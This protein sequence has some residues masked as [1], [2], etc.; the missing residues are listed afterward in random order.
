MKKKIKKQ[1]TEDEEA[2][3]IIR[4]LKKTR[5]EIL[6]D[7]VIS[8]MAMEISREIDN[9]VLYTIIST[10]KLEETKGKLCKMEIVKS[11]VHAM[12]KPTKLSND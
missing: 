1:I 9:H 3:E 7:E 11:R 8:I 2:D 6:E 10:G 5:Q 12:T 4:R